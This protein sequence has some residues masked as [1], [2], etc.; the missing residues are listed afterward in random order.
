M[1]NKTDW[2]ALALGLGIGLVGGLIIGILLAPKPGDESREVIKRQ[3]ENISD[4]WKDAT[5]DRKKVYTETW[6]QQKVRP[7]ADDLG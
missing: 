3:A 7:Y 1:D 6:K 5:A 4:R 2:G